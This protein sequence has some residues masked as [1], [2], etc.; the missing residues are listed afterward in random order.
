MQITQYVD[1]TPTDYGKISVTTA[2]VFRLDA[3]LRLAAKA[4]FITFEDES[5]KYRIDSGDPDINNGHV[6]TAGANLYFVDPY[7]IRE[8]RM[9]GFGGTATVIVTY[10]K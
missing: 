6:V 4:V 2:A 5:I 7:S 3:T 10:Y 8:L 9:I 1:R